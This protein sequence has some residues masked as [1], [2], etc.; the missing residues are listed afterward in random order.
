[1]KLSIHASEIFKYFSY[2][3]CIFFSMSKLFFEFFWVVWIAS[4]LST[5]FNK[6]YKQKI[7]ENLIYFKKISIFSYLYYKGIIFKLYAHYISIINL[8][9]S[10]NWTYHYDRTTQEWLKARDAKLNLPARF[11]RLRFD[12]YSNLIIDT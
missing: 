7:Y 11:F 3:I 12:A 4:Y 1:V 9:L 6:M 10:T 8:D 2:F 5:I